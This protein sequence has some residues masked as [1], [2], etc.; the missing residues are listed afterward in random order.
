MERQ[1]TR[2]ASA[3]RIDRVLRPICASLDQRQILDNLADVASLTLWH[4]HRV[5]RM[6]TGEMPDQALRRMR[7]HRTA[8]E[9][10]NS[11]A[12]AERIAH[13]AGNGSVVAFMRAF[14]K[15]YGHA[16]VAYRCRVRT[17]PIGHFPRT[18]KMSCTRSRLAKPPAF[19][20][21]DC[22]IPAMITRFPAAS[23][24]SAPLALP[25]AWSARQRISSGSVST[26][27]RVGRGP[28][29]VHAPCLA[30]RKRSRRR[31]FHMT[32]PPWPRCHS[33]VQG[34][35]ARTR[36]RLSDPLSRMVADQRARA[37]SP[38]CFERYLNAPS[39]CLRQS[40]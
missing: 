23:T 27:R 37:G 22:T 32:I 24:V 8:I 6:L 35:L 9:L 12:T 31:G 18:G 3:D 20:C 34:P 30:F 40:S 28:C 25:I 11:L 5:F 13:R 1:A 10:I 15:R 14:G 26:T 29:C 7:L 21:S 2:N 38:P 16:P 33:P 17:H 36:A 39:R 19:A 4:L